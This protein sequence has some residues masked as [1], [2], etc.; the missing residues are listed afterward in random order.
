MKQI[1]FSRH[2]SFHCTVS[3]FRYNQPVGRYCQKTDERHLSRYPMTTNA[4]INPT[5]DWLPLIFT[6]HPAIKKSNLAIDLKRVANRKILHSATH[7]MTLSYFTGDRTLV[8][9]ELGPLTVSHSPLC[10]YRLQVYW[11]LPLPRG[12]YSSGDRSSA[13][14]CI[15]TARHDIFCVF[16][17]STTFTRC[18]RAMTK[19]SLCCF[20]DTRFDLRMSRIIFVSQ[21]PDNVSSL[22]C[23]TAERNLFLCCLQVKY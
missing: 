4:A 10:S 9:P 12:V 17:F 3:D 16:T 21:T 18:R 15:L 5:E 2:T 23:I 6:V 7:T 19:V 13:F 20:P 1:F 14:I 22:S 11:M 8:F